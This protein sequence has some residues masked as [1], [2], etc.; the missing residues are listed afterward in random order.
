MAERAPPIDPRTAAD[1]AADVRT[2]LAVHL[3]YE[4]RLMSVDEAD[5]LVNEGRFLV[6]VALVGTNLHVRIFDANG[7]RVVNKE[8]NELISGEKLTTLKEQLNRLPDGSGLSH[9][10][11]QKIIRDAASI[12][13]HTLHEWKPDNDR[14]VTALVAVFARFAELVIERLNQAPEKNLLAFLDLLGSTRLPPQPARVPLSFSLAEGAVVDTV[15]PAGT[16]VGAAGDGQPLLFETER[17]LVVTS[18]RLQSLFVRDPINDKY[19]DRSAIF[20]AEWTGVAPAFQGEPAIEHPF[21]LGHKTLLAC[22]DIQELKLDV[23]LAT[24]GESLTL[25]WDVWDGK[26]WIDI[27]DG[28]EGIKLSAADGTAG[29]SNDGTVVFKDPPAFPELGLHKLTKLTN[30]WL[31][32]R[33]KTAITLKWDEQEKKLVPAVK[34]PAIKELTL[35]VVSAGGAPEAA[36]ADVLP[37]DLGKEFFPFGEKPK[38]GN[39][40]YLA[41]REAFSRVGA[42]VTLHMTVVAPNQ[43]IQEEA[44]VRK[45][46]TAEE[47]AKDKPTLVW[48][49]WNGQAWAPFTPTKDDSASFTK[50]GPRTMEFTVP[51]AIQPAVINGLDNYWIRVRISSGDYGKDAGINL[52]T[53]RDGQ[54][55]KDPD[56][57]QFIFTLQPS[58][59]V[60]PQLA[61]LSVGYSHEAKPEA[62]VTVNDFH[63]QV[64]KV[65]KDAATQQF[66]A[67]EPFLPPTETKPALYLGF[68]LPAGRTAFPNRP[69]S[70]YFSVAE[71]EHRYEP[72]AA[73]SASAPT[74]AFEYWNDGKTW[75]G[76]TVRDGT[77][78]LA[79]SGVVIWLAPADIAR[80]A[81]FG[82]PDHYWLRLRLVGGEYP[83]APSLRRVSLNTTMAIQATTLT[84]EVLG[85]SDGNTEQRFRANHA[86][87]LPGQALEVLEA[88][89]PT[90][91]EADEIRRSEGQDAIR[92]LEAA[93][94]RG[95][96]WVRWHEVPDFY[97]SEPRH[98]HY[99]LDRLAGM[100]RFGDGQNGLVPPRGVGNIRLARYRAGGGARG[101]VP[102]GAVSQL[103]TTVPY[104]DRVTNWEPA[105]DGADA[106][107]LAALRARAPRQLRHGF[108]AVTRDD[109]EDLALLAHPEVARAKCVPL[110]DRSQRSLFDPSQDS[111]RSVQEKHAKPGHVTVLIVPRSAAAE[112]RPSIELVRRVRDYLDL[113]R[114]PGV[115]LHVV[116]PEY[117]EIGV[118]AEIIPISPEAATFL[119]SAVEEA[120]ARFL[121]PL[122][123]GPAGA[124]W[125]FGRNASTAALYK[126]IYAVPGVAQARTLKIAP[127]APA[128]LQDTG[129]FLVRSGGHAITLVPPD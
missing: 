112:P 30:R 125:P 107:P 115:K 33:L 8:E 68:S 31:R 71:T 100:V 61:G 47:R 104:V 35:S 79:H 51:E 49:F 23:K 98:R 90:A 102:P 122:R 97:A 67:F 60:P 108:R 50:T 75:A 18:V 119:Q 74:L 72:D 128:G 89:M 65:E 87:V 10:Q 45:I 58:T 110:W 84:N 26:E 54:P 12:A 52:K 124:G 22:A 53:D 93:G 118:T 70:L 1:V 83:Q 59:L 95:A 81:D 123:G 24:P 80:K 46:P 82:L 9:E 109:Y 37:L 105:Q 63:A 15:V 101:N 85:S 7:Q 88:E 44:G 86:P 57:G 96:V 69:L 55:K 36:F 92:S 38:L 13:D 43:Y 34:L 121:H 32:C 56:D 42:K 19:A 40:F 14:L 120:L 111:Q 99:V 129:Y 16:Q 41:H 91:A 20:S 11:K 21:Y 62:I 17:D 106:E 3:G 39:S 78:A 117:L 5:G 48:E 114:L 27:W 76:T 4:L 126:A 2:L 77:E 29:L 64:E 127:P 103:K 6:I 113:H 28:K 25:R 116:G 73:L 94:P 66:K